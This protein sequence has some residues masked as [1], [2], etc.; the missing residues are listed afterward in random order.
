MRIK[1]SEIEIILE[2]LFL[3]KGITKNAGEFIKLRN[4]ER[5]WEDKWFEIV[6]AEENES[7]LDWLGDL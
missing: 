7:V 6:E 4:L 1:S 5:D 2:D 3:Q